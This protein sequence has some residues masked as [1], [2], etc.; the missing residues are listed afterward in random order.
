MG[1]ELERQ[2]RCESF[3]LIMLLF[4]NEVLKTKVQENKRLTFDVCDIP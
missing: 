3:S 2:L 1:K 4:I